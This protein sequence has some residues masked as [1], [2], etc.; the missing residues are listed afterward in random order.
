MASNRRHSYQ[1]LRARV[2]E[3]EHA[4]SYPRLNPNPVTDC[5]PTGR[6]TYLN[7]AARR[8]FPDLEHAATAHP[9]LADWPAALAALRA[10]A[11]GFRVRTIPVG[12]RWYQQTLVLVSE[13]QRVRIYGNDVTETE[14][15][16]QAAARSAAQLK[17]VL[18]SVSDGLFVVAADGTLVFANPAVAELSGLGQKPEG[19]SIAPYTQI[20]V[21]DQAGHPIPET[22]W[23]VHRALRGERVREAVCHIHRHGGGNSYL[24]VYNA[25][26][27]FEADGKVAMAVVTS[28]DVTER[29]RA[30]E[31]LRVSE[32]K[33]AKA[34]ATNPAAI[35]LTGLEDGLMVDVNDT[36]LDMF[37][38][39][40]EEVIG[41]STKTLPVWPA[42]EARERLA[43]EL[44]DKGWFR[45]REQVVMKRDGQP[46]VTLASAELL[47]IAGKPM[48]LSTWLDISQRKHIEDELREANVKLRD[49]DRHKN[50]F[51]AVLSHELRNPLAPIR[52][53]LFILDRAA[54][55]GEQERRAKQVIARQVSH[56]ASLVDD[57]LD[58][59]RVSRNKIQLQRERLDLNDL[60]R[61][62]VE[63]NRS[64]FVK[65]GVRLD[66]A[67]A[68]APLVVHAD[69]TR[70]AQIVGNLLQNAAKFTV[71]GGQT[72][73]SLARE[74]G[75]AVVRV[76]DDGVGMSE[77]TLARLFQSF[78][79]ADQ[80]LDRSKG[81]LGLG[82]ALVKGLVELHG[83]TVS[84]HSEG[85][86][87]GSAF[88]VRLALAAAIPV[89]PD[90]Q[91]EAT[92]AS[93][94]AGRHRIL[95][96]EDNVDAAVTLRDALELSRHAVEVAY[97]G[98][99]GLDKA[100]AFRPE[101][102]LCDIGLPGMDGFEVA[103]A[104]RADPT[105][106]DVFLVALSGYAQ[107]EDLQRAAEVGFQRHLA[108]P[109]NL[110]I[111]EGILAQLTPVTRTPLPRS[112]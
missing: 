11:E 3:L 21:H 75:A 5:D 6:P 26:P 92:A 83:G 15:A 38:Y 67:P 59:T 33:F 66:L 46:M 97:D 43:A 20:E 90:R 110:E 91:V 100:R 22:D 72:R 71:T 78:M 14:R 105:L 4:A 63:D 40:R 106:S 55:G 1:D 102:V 2:A 108:K 64:L 44:R 8:L 48:V 93:P 12:Q 28:R 37:G 13:Y 112:R 27:V 95:I 31:A 30:A 80:T 18:D 58:V 103:R 50:E 84:A 17:A 104:V 101:V 62:A 49:A 29:S 82:L 23:P 57:L 86:G 36:W 65:A 9:W 89:N 51:L 109:P 69:R 98:C 35:S 77:A 81:G 60:V 32:E 45:G 19:Q 107:P 73:V 24:A 94:A 61:G 25:T 52:N 10:S 99:Q 96:I 68:Q 88:T 53:S 70:M 39:R 87:K 54:P 7:P 34:F 111:L 76:V 74:E 16:K 47:T 79:Q 41:R 42:P 56:L 85:L